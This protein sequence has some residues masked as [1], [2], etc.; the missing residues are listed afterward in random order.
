M[1]RSIQFS[2]YYTVLTQTV[3]K[4]K[5]IPCAISTLPFNLRDS[6]EQI[7]EQAICPGNDTLSGR[8]ERTQITKAY[9]IW[10]PMSTLWEGI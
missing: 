1:N 10:Y 3:G 7:H 2:L 5:P 9:K 4:K 8:R 6:W